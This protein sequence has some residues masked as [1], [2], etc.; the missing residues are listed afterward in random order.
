MNVVI[1]ILAF[2]GATAT[3]CATPII[4]IFICWYSKHSERDFR[5]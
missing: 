5:W 1:Y 2:I 4:A 3:L